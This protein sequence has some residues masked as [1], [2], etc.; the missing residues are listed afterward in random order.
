MVF[1]KCELQLKRWVSFDLCKTKLTQKWVWIDRNNE[2]R[3]FLSLR[4]E[5]LPVFQISFIHSIIFYIQ[6]SISYFKF[7][8]QYCDKLELPV[9]HMY[10]SLS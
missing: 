10:G 8:N 1:E 7:L 9:C 3:I 2:S 5:N 4:D 6:N